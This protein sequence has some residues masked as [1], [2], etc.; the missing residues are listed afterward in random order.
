M[1]IKDLK[2]NEYHEF[3]ATYISKVDEKDLIEG[4]I[5]NKK[6]VVAFLNS[7]DSKL[8]EFKYAYDKW[9]IKELIQ[10]IIDTER[11]FATRAL[12]IARNDQ[13][14]LPGYNQDEFNP[15]SGANKR[16]KEELISDYNASRDNTIT[17]C[18]SFSSEM[19]LKIGKVSGYSIS[20]RAALFIIIGHENHHLQILKERYLK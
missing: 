10:H 14:D 7:I 12:R 4:L 19:L 5:Q 17:L 15:Y 20:T 16:T 3:Y 11:I 8:F 9:T 6:N 2:S 1:N 13:T 18:T